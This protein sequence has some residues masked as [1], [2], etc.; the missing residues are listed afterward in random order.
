MIAA[1]G[2]RSLAQER[3]MLAVNSLVYVIVVAVSVQARSYR[4][5]REWHCTAVWAGMGCDTVA[6]RAQSS[7]TVL[8]S[9]CTA[10]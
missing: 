7:H 3:L 1:R 6:V 8:D 10:A 2:M 5:A 4:K 9:C